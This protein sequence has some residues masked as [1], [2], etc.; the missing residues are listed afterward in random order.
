[1]SFSLQFF[2]NSKRFLKNFRKFS[3][4]KMYLFKKKRCQIHA[5]IVSSCI[6][7]KNND[8]KKLRHFYFYV[9]RFNIEYIPVIKK[10]KND[11]YGI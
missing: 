2:S 9:W 4:V 11:S 3:H 1:M 7:Y 5:L 10:L 8:K 6:V